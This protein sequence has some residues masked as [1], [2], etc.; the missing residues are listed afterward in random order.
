M[1]V[2]YIL[3]SCI[4]GG[5]TI[6][7]LNMIR[8]IKNQDIDI[9][10]I[11]PH[12]DENSEIL[13]KKVEE[14]GG[15]CIPTRI[16]SSVVPLSINIIKKILY[17][18]LL[19]GLK[20]QSYMEL[21]KIVKLEKPDIIHTNTGVVH[22]GF[23]VAK[24]LSIPHIWHL[25]E[26]Q[27]SDFHWQILP[28]KK[29]FCKLLNK[30]YTISITDDIRRFFS[31]EKK[32]KDFVFYNPIMS[33]KECDVN[34]KKKD[35][36]LVAN[37]ISPEK[38]I[39]DILS[40]F[41]VFVKTHSTYKL[42]IAGFGDSL[43]VSKLKKMAQK[44][45]CEKNVE[46]L[47]FSDNVK[48]LMANCT[49]VVVGSYSEGFGRMTAEANMLGIPVIGRNTA[50][51]KEI[52]DQTNGGIQ[53]ETIKELADSFVRISELNDLSILER[54]KYSQKRALQLFSNEQHVEHVICLYRSI[55]K[56]SN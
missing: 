33:E 29:S 14:I 36:F 12:K 47:G 49:A 24:K 26:Y 20:I 43:Y 34:R 5:A 30:S 41:S 46:F 8:G 23:L 6:S 2:L 55:L 50:G 53:F 54:M 1:K 15:R 27:I 39:E 17:Y 31:L 44:L 38:G 3:H 16:V 11:Y 48:Q 13:I 22:E 51:T 21:L 56:Q 37:R 19:Y 7:F 18:V 42:L 25:R 32:E 9:V 28:T 4:M 52:L 40:A 45:G 10:V 35:Y